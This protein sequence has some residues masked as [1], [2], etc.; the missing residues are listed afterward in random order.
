MRKHNELKMAQLSEMNI[1]LVFCSLKDKFKKKTWFSSQSFGKEE[2]WT[3]TFC[4]KRSW[5][6]TETDSRYTQKAQS[7]RFIRIWL[8]VGWTKKA[9]TAAGTICAKMSGMVQKQYQEAILILRDHLQG[10]YSQQRCHCLVSYS[11]V[12]ITLL[13]RPGILFNSRKPVKRLQAPYLVV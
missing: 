6:S 1:L 2:T 10:T 4:I 3:W 9:K 8:V 7:I 13:R 12:E 11:L 5:G